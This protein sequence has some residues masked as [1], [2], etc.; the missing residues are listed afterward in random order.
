MNPKIILA[1]GSPR[2]KELLEQIGVRFEVISPDVDETPPVGIF[3]EDAAKILAERKCEAVAFQHPDAFVI[4]AD[5][6]VLLKNSILGKPETPERARDML[7]DLSGR[8]HRVIT[9]VAFQCNETG[10]NKSISVASKVFFSELSL[11]LIERYVASGEPLDKAGG[12]GVQGLGAA[13][14]K[15]VDGS[16]WNVVGLPLSEVVEVLRAELGD[17]VVLGNQSQ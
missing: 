4:A 14:I 12:Y 2:R 10:F 17:G 16:Y 13:L 15:R 11:D 5:T 7:W 9:G 8:Q 3:P 6:I 1:S